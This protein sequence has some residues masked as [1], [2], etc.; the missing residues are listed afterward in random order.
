[1]RV[2]RRIIFSVAYI[3]LSGCE[4]NIEYV[5]DTYEVASRK[6]QT[7]STII[8]GNFLGPDDL[9]LEFHDFLEKCEFDKSL[10]LFEESGVSQNGTLVWEY[11]PNDEF[12][13]K[14]NDLVEHDGSMIK[15]AIDR[16]FKVVKIYQ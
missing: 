2:F 6:A 10:Y 15:F 4:E 7:I 9:P 8:R 5:N 14:R 1:M 16:N 12:I 13:L 3:S 11:S